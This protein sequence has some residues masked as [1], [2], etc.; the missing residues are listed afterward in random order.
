MAEATRALEQAARLTYEFLTREAQQRADAATRA[1]VEA[2]RP[3]AERTPAEL[4]K[5]TAEELEHKLGEDAPAERLDDE[6]DQMSGPQQ[7]A[8][9]ESP[10]ADDNETLQNIHAISP[11]IR[12][13]G[14]AFGRANKDVSS[15]SNDDPRQLSVGGSFGL[16]MEF[17]TQNF[18]ALVVVNK[19]AE[20]ASTLTSPREFGES[21]LLPQTEFVS[22]TIDVTWIPALW[23]DKIP[24]G[25]RGYTSVAGSTWQL[26]VVPGT[27]AD[28]NDPMVEATDPVRVSSSMTTIAGGLGLEYVWSIRSA[29]PKN[30][31]QLS[32]FAGVSLRSAVADAQAE[33]DIQALKDSNSAAEVMAL[34][35]SFVHAALD[36][37]DGRSPIFVGSDL[38]FSLRLNN[39][40]VIANLPWVQGEVPGLSRFRFVP[41]LSL[42]GGA[43]L[44]ALPRKLARKK[45]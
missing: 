21:M 25:F 23:H 45:K 22:G 32:F 5:L 26:E 15:N 16:G 38:G 39:I 7:A 24:L 34:S 14:D 28:P 40:E 44:A 41:M 30:F 31:I 2:D 42:R 12:L 13:V 1:Q 37:E 36:L 19:G 27:E 11:G 4:R 18:T 3:L 17:T 33:R 29:A 10:A 20:Q 8:L 9:A 43:Q 6:L 35:D